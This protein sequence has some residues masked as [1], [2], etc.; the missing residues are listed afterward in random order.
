M[1]P[2]VKMELH[3][4]DEAYDALLDAMTGNDDDAVLLAEKVISDRI[5]FEYPD[6]NLVPDDETLKTAKYRQRGI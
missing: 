1:M 4:S 6:V 2:T 5:H 3:L